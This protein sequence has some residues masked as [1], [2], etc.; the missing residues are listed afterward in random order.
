[1]RVYRTALIGILLSGCAGL[2]LATAISTAGAPTPLQSPRP[3]STQATPTPTIVYVQATPNRQ[4]VVF[5]T[6]APD[7]PQAAFPTR[8][9]ELDVA[10]QAPIFRPTP[11]PCPELQAA[12]ALAV[13]GTDREYAGKLQVA[14]TNLGGGEGFQASIVR[15]SIERAHQQALSDLNSGLGV[16]LANV[17]C[18]EATTP[19]SVAMPQVPT[20]AP[21]AMAPVFTPTPTPQPTG[22]PTPVPT[23][24]PTSTPKPAN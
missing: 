20:I 12:Y 13:D 10:T 9:P 2:P 6:R 8:A 19:T 23:A 4:P 14:L 11:N 1:M 3:D 5:P 15:V 17:G 22:T 24:T 16:R 21:S 18:I 7:L